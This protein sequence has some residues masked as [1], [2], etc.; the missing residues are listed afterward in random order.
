VRDN[1]LFVQSLQTFP[2]IQH[3]GVLFILAE[4][5]S[6]GSN[7]PVGTLPVG[8][9]LFLGIGENLPLKSRKNSRRQTKER[10]KARKYPLGQK[11]ASLDLRIQT[12]PRF[13]SYLPCDICCDGHNKLR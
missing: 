7:R 12:K 3:F 9:L 1:A 4:Q 11:R 6:F 13:F 8:N 2:R 10:V 5:Y